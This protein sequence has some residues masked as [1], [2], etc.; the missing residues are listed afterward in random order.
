MIPIFKFL[1]NPSLNMLRIC[2]VVF[3]RVKPLWP[4]RYRYDHTDIQQTDT[5]TDTPLQNLYQTDTDN[6]FAIT[7]TDMYQN[8]PVKSIQNQYQSI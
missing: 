3:F 6:C 1:L 4:Y 2:W 7:D 5:D 8:L